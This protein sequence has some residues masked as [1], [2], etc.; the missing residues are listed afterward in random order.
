MALDDTSDDLI[1]VQRACH[2]KVKEYTFFLSAH[3]TLSKVDHMWNHKTSIGKIRKAKITLNMFSS[4]NAVRPEINTRKKTSL[5][6]KHMKARKYAT[7]PLM[8][9]WRNHIGRQKMYP[10]TYK[11]TI[12]MIQTLWI[13]VKPVLRVKCT[14]I[15]AYLRKR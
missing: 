9:H 12:A 13:K 6:H 3:R 10:E 2:M 1:D 11:N 15:H 8:D 4:H 14:A 7:K 5:N